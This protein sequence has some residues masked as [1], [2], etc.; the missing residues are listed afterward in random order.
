MNRHLLSLRIWS[1]SLMLILAACNSAPAA[2]PRPPL[3]PLP[4]TFPSAPDPSLSHL[5]SVM[6]APPSGSQRPSAYIFSV[7]LPSGW[8]INHPQIG[9]D[10]WSG[11]L[12]GDG[13][14]LSISGGAFAVSEIYEIVGNGPIEMDREKAARHIIT[15]E[16]IGN[17]QATLVRPREVDDGLTGLIFKL[18][19]GKVTITGRSLSEEEQD[20]AFEIFRSIRR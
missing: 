12:V 3:P 20:V 5:D 18:P 19:T 1:V 10:S 9:V 8:T 16:T 15:E 13:V 4:P 14:T 2:P 6:L 11:S 7:D 17:L